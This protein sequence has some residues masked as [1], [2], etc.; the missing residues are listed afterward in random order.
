MSLVV[1]LLYFYLFT[2]PVR[3]FL[4]T[5]LHGRLTCCLSTSPFTPEEVY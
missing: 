5:F 1:L 4:Y 3:S 2:V